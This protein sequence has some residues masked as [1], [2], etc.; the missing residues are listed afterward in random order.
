MEN[1][2]PPLSP[3]EVAVLREQIESEIREIRELNRLIKIELD[4]A[5]SDL[6]TA[7][8]SNK[9]LG[10]KDFEVVVEDVK[11]LEE[12]EIY[13]KHDDYFNLYPT[14][15]ETSYY[16]NLVDNPRPI[17]VKIDPK[18][19]RGDPK[20]VKIPCV[21]GYK[22]IDNAY[23]DFES[24]INIMSSSVY[25]DIVKTR[26]GPRK[27]P[28]YPGGVCNF[29]GRVKGLRVFVGNFTFVTDF[30]I[31]E[32]LA[33][34]ID[35]RLSNVV[36]GKPFVEESKLEYDEIEGTIRFASN[37]DR[38][39]YRMPNRMK[40]FR[41]ISRFD[42]DNV[43][44][45]EDINEEDKKKGM[46]YVWEKRSLFYKDCLALGPRYK[47]DKEFAQRIMGAIEK[48]VIGFYKEYLQ[49]ESETNDEVT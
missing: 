6:A 29:V 27:D 23:I 46:D 47:V 26:L 15:E 40:E 7:L 5:F 21:I 25:N 48:K 43:G 13:P 36:F 44:A 19:K 39:T 22:H 8:Y 35:C 33:N 37:T 17:F 20:N 12:G 11:G 31:V 4:H 41:F 10:T 9:D 1:V 38:I 16:N 42:K 3:R 45:F 18:I 2:N 30:M 24:P 34:V 28:K 49:S 32:D 14:K